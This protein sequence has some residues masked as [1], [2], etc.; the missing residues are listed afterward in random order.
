M[1]SKLRAN[2]LRLRRRLPPGGNCCTMRMLE[3]V[4]PRGRCTITALPSSKIIL[5]IAGL[6]LM[7]LVVAACGEDSGPQPTRIPPTIEITPTPRSTA[8]PEVEEAAAPGDD[9]R[10]II[11]QIALFGDSVSGATRRAGI[12][13]QDELRAALDLVINVEFV[14]E[15]AA[16][17]NLCSGQPYVVWASA[18]T[19]AAANAQCDVTPRQAIQRGRTPE[20]TIGRSAEIVART[21]ITAIG[22]LGEGTFCRS[23]EHD[24]FVTWVYPSLLL[25]AHNIDPLNELDTVL[26]YPDDLSLLFALYEGNCDAAGLPA[27]I[28]EDYLVDIALLASTDQSQITIDDV[29]ERLHVLVD[30]GN[31]APPVDATDGDLIF[32][33][34]TIPYGLLIFPASPAI[35]ANIRDDLND[36]ISD[37]F[38][39]RTEGAERLNALLDATALIPVEQ[40]SYANFLALIADS[41]WN[42]TFTE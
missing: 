30:A 4:R 3:I 38:A 29:E 32:E 20:A 19:Y 41:G 33:P 28:F 24:L 21:D 40:S 11:V 8:L 37:F 34:N 14:T 2:N 39:D 1:S 9:A 7:T 26:D 23:L 35:P 42:M 18:F 25:R 10:P 15:T 5:A 36:A 13:L 27:G 16:L 6:L 31:T 17:E 22:E 12:E